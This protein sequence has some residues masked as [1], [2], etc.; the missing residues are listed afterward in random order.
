MNLATSSNNKITPF[1]LL[2]GIL[3]ISTLPALWHTGCKTTQSAGV[4]PHKQEKTYQAEPYYIDL[5]EYEKI[6][7]TRNID[8]LGE[9]PVILE[10]TEQAESL[11]AL[12][13]SEAVS[14]TVATMP[15]DFKMILQKYKMTTGED[16]YTYVIEHTDRFI[17]SPDLKRFSIPAAGMAISKYIITL[18]GEN[19]TFWLYTGEYITFLNTGYVMNL[20]LF[21]NWEIVNISVHEAAHHKLNMLIQGG[22]VSREYY[23]DELRERYAFIIN[24]EFLYALL[25]EPMFA[26][27]SREYRKIEYYIS[28]DESEVER[29]NEQL[30]LEPS[31]RTLLPI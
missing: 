24:L 21:S 2:V 30:G 9:K 1:F 28:R 29:Y 5:Q 15:K 22:K 14:F 17:L 19:K 20:D 7:K 31:N 11:Y 4:T 27:G 12:R 13:G 10:L 26:R 18:S 16:F 6:K 23:Y 8:F 3:V 25:R